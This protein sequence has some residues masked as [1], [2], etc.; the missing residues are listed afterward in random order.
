MSQTRYPTTIA[1]AEVPKNFRLKPNF[2]VLS[3]TSQRGESFGPQKQSRHRV[4]LLGR[5]SQ[6]LRPKSQDGH[7]W[8]SWSQLAS[9]ILLNPR[10]E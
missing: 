8:R 7:S 6:A 4:H 9:S 5:T 3:K 1:P 2:V 10:F